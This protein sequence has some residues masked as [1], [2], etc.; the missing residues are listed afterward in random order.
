[1]CARLFHWTRRFLQQDETKTHQHRGEMEGS[2]SRYHDF[3]SLHSIFP[4]TM[5]RREPDGGVVAPVSARHGQAGP[6]A[7]SRLVCW[8]P[9]AHAARLGMAFWRCGPPMGAGRPA[10]RSPVTGWL[11]GLTAGLLDSSR[12]ATPGLCTMYSGSSCQGR[13][14][15]APTT[16][17]TET[18]THRTGMAS[19]SLTHD[20]IDGFGAD[21][22][23]S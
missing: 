1:M 9:A 19:S 23:T 20:R 17:C 18:T 14:G 5:R 10:L 8:P 15:L 6:V 22:Q 3:R 13:V 16:W 7:S 12:G 2:D 4:S 21:K 11:A